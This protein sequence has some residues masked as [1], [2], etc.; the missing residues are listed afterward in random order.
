MNIAVTLLTA[1]PL[2]L[3]V[4]Q[5]RWAL[6]TYLLIECWAFTF[7]TLYVF[8]NWAGAKAGI[9]GAQ[10]FGP[11]PT[12]FPL[13]YKDSEVIAY[14]VVNLVICLVGI[15]L[16]LLGHRLRNRRRPTTTVQVS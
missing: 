1:L 3:F 5:R 9:G 11:Y 8:L 13:D 10:A 14:G 4:R 12:R 6:A 16:V 2:G 15:G 7:Q